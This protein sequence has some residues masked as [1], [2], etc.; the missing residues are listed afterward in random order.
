MTV[1]D[2][3]Y[4]GQCSVL[5]RMFSTV[6]NVQY[7]GGYSVLLRVFVTVEGDFYCAGIPFSTVEDFR[8][9]VCISLHL[10]WRNV[11]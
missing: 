5:W 10:Q 1:E 3:Q 6:E 2:I 11:I 9:I 8:Y 7:C 4:Y